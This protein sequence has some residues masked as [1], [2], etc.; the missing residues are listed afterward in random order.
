MVKK[1]EAVGFGRLNHYKM[2]APFA[3]QFAAYDFV[4]DDSDKVRPVGKPPIP[5]LDVQLHGLFIGFG[6]DRANCASTRRA[7][8]SFHFLCVKSG[9]TAARQ[10][11]AHGHCRAVPFVLVWLAA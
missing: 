5:A 4:S 9:A 7:S 3:G 1:L 2:L 11:P 8:V 6:A 10:P